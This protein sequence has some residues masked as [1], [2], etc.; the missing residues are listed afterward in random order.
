MITTIVTNAQDG[1]FF[2]NLGNPFKSLLGK[3]DK[4]ECCMASVT[5]QFGISQEVYE[6]LINHHCQSFSIIA[7]FSDAT[8][9]E[10]N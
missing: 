2:K 10:L 8:E 1:K 6:E 9:G 5:H 3:N 4:P 7:T